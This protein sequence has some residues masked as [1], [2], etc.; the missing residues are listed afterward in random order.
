MYHR[1]ETRQSIQ[2][3]S[4]TER[5]ALLMTNY[6]DLMT[7][8]LTSSA[9]VTESFNV[10]MRRILDNCN[11]LFDNYY[12]WGRDTNS[13]ITENLSTTT[14]GRRNRRPRRN[15]NTSTNLSTNLPTTNTTPFNMTPA[16]SESL[17]SWADIVR[18]PE[19][20]R[21]TRD[22]TSNTTNSTS[23]WFLMVQIHVE[24]DAQMYV[25]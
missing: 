21:S 17:R 14:R 7:N 3:M 20:R 22:T 4:D 24:I 18:N 5:E 6:I 10:S 23:D 15:N 2:N 13:E 25:V 11:S 9:Q 8:V 12:Q 1:R 19:T 16:G